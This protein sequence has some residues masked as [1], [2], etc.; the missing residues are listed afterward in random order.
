MSL[1]FNDRAPATI[2]GAVL[3]GKWGGGA[4]GGESELAGRVEGVQTG[5]IKRGLDYE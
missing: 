4:E 3:Q 1:N 2:A 5:H